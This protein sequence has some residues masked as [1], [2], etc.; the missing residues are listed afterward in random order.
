MATIPLH[1]DETDL[2]KIDYLVKKGQYKNRSQAIKSLLLEQL[3]RLL[4]P[5]E[6]QE[7]ESDRKV[8][9]VVQKL[10][11]LPEREVAITFE[12]R[13]SELISE[14]RDRY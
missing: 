1:I 6:F 3:N 12:K 8:D 2:K 9:D 10:L 14:E 11:K 7:S 4:I 13:L 5:F